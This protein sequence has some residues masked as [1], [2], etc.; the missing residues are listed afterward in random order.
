MDARRERIEHWVGDFC[1]SPRFRAQPSLVREYAPEVLVAFL[2]SACGARDREPA[3]VEEPD[4]KP[5]LLEGVARVE[6]PAS[7][8]GDVPALCGAF[9]EEMEAQGRLA[10]GRTLGLYVAALREAYL[11]A[12][13]GR[14]PSLTRPAPKVGRNDPCPCGSG[15]KFKKCCLPLDTGPG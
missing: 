13:A 3:D 11:D 9:L 7:V 5:G 1:D 12:A 2:E 6:I 14:A 4:V 8:R 10:G 15:R